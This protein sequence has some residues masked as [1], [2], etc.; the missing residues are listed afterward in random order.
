[1]SRTTSSN[2]KSPMRKPPPHLSE[3]YSYVNGDS[4]ESPSTNTSPTYELKKGIT[5][6]SFTTQHQSNG[7][8]SANI[9]DSPTRQNNRA[10]SGYIPKSPSKTY[11]QSYDPSVS[12][13]LQHTRKY[14]N[15]SSTTNSVLSMQSSITPSTLDLETLITKNDVSGTVKCYKDLLKTAGQY[16]EALM[17]VSN[18]ASEFGR[19][20]Q[21]CAKCKGS[22]EASDGLMTSSGLHYLIANHQQILAHSIQ[23]KFEEPVV[24]IVEKFQENYETNDLNFKKNIQDKVKQLKRNETA[25]I[26]LSKK[27][28]RN[29]ISYKSNLLQ[30]A[31]QLDEIDRLK[32]DYYVSSFDQ[33]QN[34]SLQ[35]LSKVSS[36]VSIETTIYE[37]IGKKAW[38]GGGL[39]DLLERFCS[40]DP[41]VSA[42][43]EFKPNDNDND[44]DDDDTAAD[45]TIKDDDN[46]DAATAFQVTNDEEFKEDTQ[47]DQ[48]T[49]TP[50]QA[51]TAGPD[52]TF[53]APP[54]A[55]KSYSSTTSNESKADS[56]SL[57][58][59]GAQRDEEG[60]INDNEV[61]EFNKD[62]SI[63]EDE[64]LDNSSIL[65]GVND[66][67]IDPLPESDEDYDKKSDDDDDDDDDENDI[68]NDEDSSFSLPTANISEVKVTNGN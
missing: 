36:I 63:E 51:T 45:I 1:M 38:S 24:D 9:D 65:K 23:T 55:N 41:F 43:E 13:L 4:I 32:H 11:K 12:P 42:D 18:A 39:D 53:Y 28:T 62:A 48:I 60:L 6:S 44:V 31:S 50:F 17:V 58:Q 52:D 68:G 3:F 54:I 25:N 59:R 27:K 14:T 49:D 57:V 20:L 26:K 15:Q 22:G 40:G 21:D 29:I 61:D 8:G 10:T 47:D 56:P 34:S 7:F 33:V 35:I 16:R 19:A 66:I 30:L 64:H 37:N 2:K 67:A 5:E 46:I